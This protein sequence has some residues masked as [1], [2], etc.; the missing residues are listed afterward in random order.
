VVRYSQHRAPVPALPLPLALKG[1]S[2]NNRPTL[3]QCLVVCAVPATHLLRGTIER[4][5][6]GLVLRYFY[7]GRG[8]KRRGRACL[9][10]ALAL[11]LLCW[12]RLFVE[13]LARPQIGPAN[14][15][16]RISGTA[17]NPGSGNAK[18]KI[19]RAGATSCCIPATVLLILRA[20][21]GLKPRALF[22]GRTPVGAW[23]IGSGVWRN[24]AAN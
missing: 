24:R 22:V 15:R 18:G 17:R 3:L 2:A 23:R 16:V 8:S 6:G 19:L 10:A 20:S 4:H 21:G 13:R 5:K 1:S 12:R 11:S 9:S 7:V 14:D